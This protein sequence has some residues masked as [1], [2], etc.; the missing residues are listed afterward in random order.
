MMST[1][2]GSYGE[3][4]TTTM[5]VVTWN[6]WWRFGPWEQRHP[7]I[8]S[9]LRALDPDV[10]ALQEV[11]DDGDRNQAALLGGALGLHHV[12][13]ANREMDGVRFG[14][15]VLSRWPITG[16]ESVPLP[17]PPEL[18]EGRN[19]LRADVDG[20][21]GPLQVFSTHLNWRYDHSHVRQEQVGAIAEFVRAAPKRSFPPIVCG[22]FNA[23]PDSDEIRMMTGRTTT[24]VEGLVFY[25]AWEAAGAHG[26]PGTTWSND[27]PWASREIEVDRRIDFVF[28]GWPR[29]GG[30]G[31]VTSCA[32][33]GRDPVDGV[34]PSD[35]YAVRADLRY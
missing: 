4:V 29:M 12:Y 7:A 16:D 9:T 31:H 19:V 14:N 10:V 6:L 33:E 1:T 21:R 18:D 30:L 23:L 24:P 8:E 17:A 35:H 26:E 20:P 3:L 32:V 11:W 2:I 27:N 28:V 22:D 15:A 34:V 5:R 13:S 25:D